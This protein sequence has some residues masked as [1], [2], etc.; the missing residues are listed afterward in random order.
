MQAVKGQAARA[1][2]EPGPAE[3]AYQDASMEPPEGPLQ[4]DGRASEDEDMPEVMPEDDQ[5][6]D[7][8]E[9]GLIRMQLDR[10]DLQ[11]N[12]RGLEGTQMTV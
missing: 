4:T 12:Q 8:L 10:Q 9:G 1:E 3:G 2:R 6:A 11:P 7:S 5:L